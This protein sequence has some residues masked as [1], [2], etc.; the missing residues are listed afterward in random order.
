MTSPDDDPAL[1]A[2]VERVRAAQADGTPLEIAGHGSK[3]FY[4]GPRHGEA[5]HTT[6]LTGISSYEPTELVVSARAG[7]PIAELEAALAEHGQCLPFEPPRFRVGSVAKGTVG[8]LVAAGLSGPSRASVGAVR[9]HV[10]GA[11]LLNGRAEVLSFGGQVMKN[12]AGYDVSRLLCGSMGVLGVVLEVSLKVLPVQP[13]TAT[14]RFELDEAAA[15]Q[16][17]NAWGGQPLPVSASAWWAGMLLLRLRGARAAVNAAVD[18]LLTRHRGEGVED[19][20]ATPFWDGLR[21]H[22]DEFFVKARTAVESNTGAALW[23]LSVP[24]TAAPIALPGE[25]LIE[26]GGAQ[27]WWCTAASA[28]TVREAA[29]RAGG[30]ATLFRGGDKTAG[31]F[32]PLSA[33]LQ[34]IQRELKREFDPAGVFNRGRLYPDL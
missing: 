17:L 19:S 20:L 25:Q 12:V 1:R 26:W 6:G 31:V 30:H 23:R 2:L 16:Q 22:E 33:P 18:T 32:T 5:L 15:L 7:T 14:L 11:T 13:A 9:D 10:L 8:G 4:G 34:R 28:A 29:Q 3:A 27:R 21:D 24:Q